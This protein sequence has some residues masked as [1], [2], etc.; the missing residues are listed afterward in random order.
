MF[1]D[2]CYSGAAGGRTFMSKRTRGTLDDRFLE[3]LTKS[4][5][6]VVVTASRPSEVAL[7]LPTLRHGIF[8]YYLVQGLK[9]AADADG[10][11]IVTLNEIYQYVEREVR[12]RSR[13][14]GGNQQPVMRGEVEGDL[15]IT[16]LRP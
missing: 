13:Q 5:G 11:G 2:A 16:R 9:G 6:R 12:T 8:T 1:V 4:R 3:R 7:E 14:E 10:D 15:P